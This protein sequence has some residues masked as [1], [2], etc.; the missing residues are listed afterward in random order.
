MRED[1]MPKESSIVAL[2]GSGKTLACGSSDCADWFPLRIWR[3][4]GRSGGMNLTPLIV[5]LGWRV[6]YVV[7]SSVFNH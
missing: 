5:K 1:G 4:T 7:V 6:W 3:R 2:A